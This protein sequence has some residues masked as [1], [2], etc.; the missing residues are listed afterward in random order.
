MNLEPVIKIS[1]FTYPLPDERIAKYPLAERDSSKL[2][3]YKDGRVL[4]DTFYNIASHI[5]QDSFMVFNNTKV[6]PARLF[7]RKKTGALIEILCLNP[8]SPAEYIG[9][10]SSKK[11]CSWSVVVGNAKKWKG[12]EL[13]FYS[14][15]I[16]KELNFRVELL[17]KGEKTSV[18]LFKWDTDETFSEVLDRCGKVPIPP[19][20]NRDTEEID[21]KRY[22][23][24]YARFE[25]SVA[26]PTAGL[27]FTDRVLNSL[28]NKNI[29]RE[30]VCL[31]VGAGTF[32]PVKSEFISDHQMHSEPFSVSKEF[33]KDLVKAVKKGSVVAVGTTSTRTLESLYYIG[34]QCIE[35]PN[36]TIRPVSQWEPYNRE[37]KYDISEALEAI[38]SYLDSR[39]LS[40]LIAATSIIIVP[41]FKYRVVDMLVTNFHQPQST[42]LLLISAFI[43]DDWRALYTHALE[44]GYRFLSYGDSSLLFKNRK[45]L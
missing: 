40:Q 8:V 45:I 24:I 23:T 2:L 5:P 37:Y 1:D 7:F 3:V 10:F 19:Y 25:G 30:N 4:D 11:S 21:K 31:H 26:A 6:V 13:Y 33:L 15:S 39:S 38:V 16:G 44:S 14:D 22:Q 42:L 36:E 43:G 9:S 17:Q 18:V 27:H 20:L 28:D 35:H 12:G 34:V 29:K 32:A 41:G